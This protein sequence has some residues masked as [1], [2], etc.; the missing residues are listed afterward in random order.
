M[1]D[2]DEVFRSGHEL[3]VPTIIGSAPIKLFV[4]DSGASTGIISPEAARLVTHV[5]DNSDE[6]DLRGLS[7]RVNKVEEA[8]TIWIAFAGVKQKTDAMTTIDLT[9]NS[10]QA[11]TEISGFIGF[12]TLRQVT[13]A[14]DYRDN[15]IHVTYDPK[16]DGMH[17]YKRPRIREAFCLRLRLF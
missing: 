5:N 7:G 8:K 17:Y 13:L 3:I 4:L 1:K 15:L 9:R 16:H 2:W 11:G 6:H 12:P 14:I 10:Q